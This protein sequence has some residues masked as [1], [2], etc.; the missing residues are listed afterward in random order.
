MTHKGKLLHNEEARLNECLIKA[1]D[2]IQVQIPLPGGSDSEGDLELLKNNPEA[3]AAKIA[4]RARR[5]EGGGSG[6]G[7]VSGIKGIRFISADMD[8][9]NKEDDRM[10]ELE[11]DEIGTLG[12]P[13]QNNGMTWFTA[14]E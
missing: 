10:V 7:G 3:Y 6:A 9:D 8:E 12:P 4:A 11:E 14:C 13:Y 2:T 1:Y 5:S